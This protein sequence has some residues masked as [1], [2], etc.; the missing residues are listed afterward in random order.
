MIAIGMAME[1]YMENADGL[2]LDLEIGD[3]RGLEWRS[4]AMRMCWLSI[5]STD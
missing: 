3:G 2:D 5:A 4:L 1:K